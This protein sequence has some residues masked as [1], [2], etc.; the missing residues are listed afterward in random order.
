MGSPMSTSFEMI[1]DE[2]EG[3][4][5]LDR[6]VFAFEKGVCALDVLLLTVE[7]DYLNL[8]PAGRVSGGITHFW[9]WVN[10]MAGSRLLL[11]I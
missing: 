7:R 5:A 1:C 2:T 8:R 3:V 9:T 10:P 4:F 6:G 11:L